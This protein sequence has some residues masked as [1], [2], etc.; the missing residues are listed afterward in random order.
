MLRNIDWLSDAH[1]TLF[2]EGNTGHETGHLAK[3]LLDNDDNCSLFSEPEAKVKR[4]IYQ[5]MHTEGMTMLEYESKYKDNFF[6][7]NPGYT[8]STANKTN[9]L[10]AS[11]LKISTGAVVFADCCFSAD[12]YNLESSDSAKLE[13]VKQKF[14]DQLMRCIIWKRSTRSEGAEVYGWS[15]K[16]NAQGQK[17]SGYNDDIAVTFAA[18][19]WM[20]PMAMAGK[21]LGFPYS[22]AR[23]YNTENEELAQKESET[24]AKDYFFS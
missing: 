8:P 13:K 10:T 6:N 19:C 20:W 22:K 2:T 15:G 24:I 17:Q 21:L 14:Y 4:K 23:F 9:W 5:K 3:I 16:A 12:P 7:L 11:R 1:F 18:L